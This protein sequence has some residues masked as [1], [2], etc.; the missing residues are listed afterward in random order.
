VWEWIATSGP[1]GC[2]RIGILLFPEHRG[3]GLGTAAQRLLTDYLFST[4]RPTG[5]RRPPRPTTSLSS[6]R[7]RRRDSSAR[8][9]CAARDSCVAD[10]ET[11]CC[12]PACV[13][14]QSHLYEPSERSSPVQSYPV[15]RGSVEDVADR[16]LVAHLPSR[17][18]TPVRSWGVAAANARPHGSTPRRATRTVV[19]TLA[20]RRRR[21]TRGRRSPRSLPR[22]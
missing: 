15:L 17:H 6:G 1:R 5:W 2:L 22:R 19:A 11:A 16:R 18:R 12:T 20:P 13:T 21:R 4:P 8:A 14:T 9:C 3:K 10:G 7:W